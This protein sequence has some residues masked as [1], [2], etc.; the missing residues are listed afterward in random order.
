MGEK[1]SDMLAELNGLVEKLGRDDCPVD[2]LEVMVRRASE[3]IKALK[4]R[5]TATEESVSSMLRELED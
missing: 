4:A 3:L 2:E 5:L 1:Y